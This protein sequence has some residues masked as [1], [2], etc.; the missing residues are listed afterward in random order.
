MPVSMCMVVVLPA[1]LC[2]S[3]AVMRPFLIDRSTS[4]TATLKPPPVAGNTLRRPT[5]RTATSSLP[6]CSRCCCCCCCVAVLSP[7]PARGLLF[8]CQ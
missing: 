4:S 6:S 2:P 5:T 1:P 7:L 8:A 3:S